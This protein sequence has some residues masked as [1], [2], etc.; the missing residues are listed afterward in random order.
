MDWG[1]PDHVTI[2]VSETEQSKEGVQ[3]DDLEAG[4]DNDKKKLLPASHYIGE[5]Y[6]WEVTEKSEPFLSKNVNN[7]VFF[8][9]TEKIDIVE[10]LGKDQQPR[11]LQDEGMYIG[12]TPVLSNRNQNKLEH[13]ILKA[14]PYIIIPVRCYKCCYLFY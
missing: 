7:Q 2:K 9:P 13:R 8:A 14:R 1:P 10:K 11:F 6:L 3:E 12:V 5:K 4:S